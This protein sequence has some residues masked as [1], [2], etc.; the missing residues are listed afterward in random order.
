ML[1]H[2]KSYENPKNIDIF[3][4]N[5]IMK[6]PINYTFSVWTLCKILSVV[7]NNQF[8]VEILEF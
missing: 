5:G 2:E 4:F 6:G 7:G 1:A 3:N 8:L